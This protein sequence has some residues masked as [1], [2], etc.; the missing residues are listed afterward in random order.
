MLAAVIEMNIE[1]AIN[2][3]ARV[4]ED[5]GVENARN[6]AASLLAFSLRK[7]R[8]FLIAHPEYEL[9]ADKA[10][11]YKSVVRRRAK[12]EPFQHITR[13]Q[14]FYGLDFLVTPD[15]LVPR[16]ETE[17]LVETAI[18]ELCDLPAPRICEIGVGS[19][20]IV[21]SILKNIA[22]ATAIA[23]DVSK[24]AI[25]IAR[26]NAEAH[27]TSDRVRFRDS[28][29]YENVTDEFFDA[30]VSNPPYIAAIEID[31]LQPEVRC[32]DPR[33]ALT[34]EADGLSIIRMIVDGAP[35]RLKP[36]ALLL[37]EV[38]HGQSESVKKMF[39]SSRWAGVSFKPDLQG[40]P[41][42]VVARR[43]IT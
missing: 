3:G 26:Q 8:T 5:A 13:T 41:R 18:E 2:A 21:V 9:S 39:D 25:E 34:D 32:F 12:R 24:S 33:V 35:H 38:G 17:I 28:N 10:I 36:G 20:C 40:I 43:A 15:V 23:V 42:V 29:V 27:G 31:G 37:I 19:G 14:E 11:L 22:A 1:A 6:E 16:P 30:I 7:D 4:L